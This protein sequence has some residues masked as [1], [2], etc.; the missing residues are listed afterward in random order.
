MQSNT[1]ANPCAPRTK[2]APIIAVD[3]IDAS[4]VRQDHNT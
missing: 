1:H 4:V 2:T 3:A